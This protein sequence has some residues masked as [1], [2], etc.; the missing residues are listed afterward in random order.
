MRSI[1][2]ASALA[3]AVGACAPQPKPL[4]AADTELHNSFVAMTL[5]MNIADECPSLT[6]L[7]GGRDAMLAEVER[8]RTES[9]LSLENFRATER[10][11]LEAAGRDFSRFHS[12]YGTTPGNAAAFCAAGRAEIKAGSAIGRYLRN[13]G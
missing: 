11:R 2:I 1:V 5:A 3:L 8:K 4:S 12:K 6:L 9:G 13:K 7:P 10:A